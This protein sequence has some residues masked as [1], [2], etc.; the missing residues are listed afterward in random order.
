MTCSNCDVAACWA[1]AS[2]SSRRHASS[3][4]SSGPSS[5]ELVALTFRPADRIFRWR[6]SVFAR[7]ADEDRLDRLMPLPHSLFVFDGMSRAGFGTQ[8]QVTDNPDEPVAF[9]LRAL[10]PSSVNIANVHT[11]ST[12][13]WLHMHEPHRRFQ[14]PRAMVS[15]RGLAFAS[16]INPGTVSAGTA[17]S[18]R[19]SRSQVAAGAEPV[20]EHEVL[21]EAFRKRPISGAQASVGQPA[22]KPT[23]KRTGRDG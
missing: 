22:A 10:D 1:S 15:E 5:R 12:W 18:L 20:L 9:S 11:I 14:H 4:V 3:G 7:L 17:P 16:A 19:P 8:R 13:G 23:I 2:A 21:A 6:F